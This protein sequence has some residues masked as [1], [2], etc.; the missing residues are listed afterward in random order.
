[1]GK[2]F[3]DRAPGF[4]DP[5]ACDRRGGKHRRFPTFGGGA[6]KMHDTLEFQPRRFGAD[7]IVSVR[8]VHEQDV[9]D[10]KNSLFH[11]LELVPGTGDENEKKAIHHGAHGDFALADSDGFDEHD[12]E[13]SRL[14]DSDGFPGLPGHTS[15]RSARRRRPDETLLP[16]REG[17]H[18]GFVAENAAAR[19]RTAR[20]HRQHG[21]LVSC[22]AE[23]VAQ[24]LNQCAFTS[25]GDT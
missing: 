25:S 3:F 22:V 18:A 6:E 16:S 11:P 10:F 13:A 1:M 9:R 5:G 20:V 23:M 8:L 21:D 19:Q 7:L 24:S 15:E 17:F 12:I 14:A 4:G 2:I